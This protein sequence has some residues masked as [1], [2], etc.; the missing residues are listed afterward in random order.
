MWDWFGIY[1]KCDII[2]NKGGFIKDYI[3]IIEP[4]T[5]GKTGL[6]KSLYNHYKGVYIKQNMVPEFNIKSVDEDI[7]WRKDMFG[8]RFTT[9]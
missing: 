5:V 8:K 4:S 2:K 7:F 6:T 3:F 1:V 9:D